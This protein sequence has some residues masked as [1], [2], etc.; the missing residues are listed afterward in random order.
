VEL[1]RLRRERYA[2]SA[3]TMPSVPSAPT[4]TTNARAASPS[5]PSSA[6]R[7]ATAAEDTT[8]P[9]LWPGDWLESDDPRAR[10]VR[11]DRASSQARDVAPVRW[12]LAVRIEDAE[13]PEDVES[14]NVRD[15]G[16]GEI[17][18]TIGQSSA[19][20]LR[21]I[22]TLVVLLARLTL[23]DMRAAGERIAEMIHREPRDPEPRDPGA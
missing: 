19:V 15:S 11:A 6:A 14:P 23:E 1:R 22:F 2:P 9:A 17:W 7:A 4:V 13:V 12:P 8:G 3:T 10:T 20:L 18:R 5:R 16:L 21:A